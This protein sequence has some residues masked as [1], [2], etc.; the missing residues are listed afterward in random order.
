MSAR[1]AVFLDRDDTLIANVPYL[2]DPAGLRVLP[3]ASQ[4]LG[5]LRR[6]GFA[7][8]LI[9]NQSAVGRGLI[10]ES[11]LH[12]IHDALN[13]LLAEEGAAL[14]AIY[15]CPEVPLGDDRTIIENP[16]RKPG[17][18]ML[19]RATEELDL[20]LDASWMV[21]DQISDVLAGLNAGCRS[22]LVGSN[23]TLSELPTEAARER[24]FAVSD[25]AAAAELILNDHSRRLQP[26]EE[27]ARP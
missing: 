16:N 21:G 23:A 3:G 6:A 22:I 2:S 9:T 18:G 26:R 25:F 20:D 8:V 11:R 13:R 12:E 14:D 27:L 24:A 15:Y 17:P 5:A 1:P 10:T 19:H 7:L 4:A